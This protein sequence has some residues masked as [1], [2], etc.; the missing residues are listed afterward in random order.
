MGEYG[1]VDS[2][3]TWVFERDT[4]ENRQ[5]TSNWFKRF[6]K[7][8]GIKYQGDAYLEFLTEDIETARSMITDSQLVIHV[9]KHFN[10]G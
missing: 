4:R 2:T 7:S 3:E 6:I 8:S 9:R 5:A 10:G 1:K